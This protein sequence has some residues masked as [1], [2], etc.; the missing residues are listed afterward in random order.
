MIGTT[1]T[2]NA[3]H[4]SHFPGSYIDS[5]C[6]LTTVNH[7]IISDGFTLLCSMRYVVLHTH[8]QLPS[9]YTTG[10]T[11]YKQHVKLQLMNTSL[12]PPV[13]CQSR[14]VARVERNTIHQKI[15]VNEL[16]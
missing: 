9:E 2:H 12:T 6:S 8:H 16:I 3:G 7:I 14:L 4:W 1:H 5:S 11:D 15:L 10:I 13:S